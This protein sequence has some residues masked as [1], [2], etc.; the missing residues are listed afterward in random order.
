LG[1]YAVGSV[2][3]SGRL[4]VRTFD[5]PLMAINYARLAQV[6]FNAMRLLQLRRSDPEADPAQLQE[7][8]ARLQELS[9]SVAEDLDVAEE[10][11]ISKE[12]VAAT[13]AARERFIGWNR[14][15]RQAIAEGRS[16]SLHASLTDHVEAVL[17]AFDTLGEVMADDGF[18]D[19]E[20]SLASVNHY[21]MISIGATLGALALGL[22]IAVVLARQMVDPIAA[23]SRAAS[24]IAAGDLDA[25]ILPAGRDELG[26]LLASMAVMRENIR[27]MMEKEIAARR[28]AQTQL[29]T[30]IESSHEG[31]ALID[32][33]SRI[34]IANSPI[35][36]F[37]AQRGA[38]FVAGQRLPNEVAHALAERTSEMQL[39]DGQWLRLS[40][41][42]TPE[43]GFVLIA[44]DI[45]LLKAREDAL[46]SA[47]DDAEAANRAK[48][49]FLATMSH[50]L[51]TPLSAVIGFSELIVNETLGP[52]G[53]PQYREFAADILHAGKHLLDVITDI[54]DVAKAQSGTTVLRLNPLR[55][56]GVVQDAVRIV[57]NK[58]QSAGLT[59]TVDIE[60]PLPPLRADPV[61]LRQILL[62]LLSNAIK[63]TPRGG[64]V[65]VRVAAFQEGLAIEVADT[66]IGMAKDDIPRAMEP[67]VQVD[68]S[69]NR[70]HGGTG[71]GLPLTKLFTE[72]HGGRLEIDSQP[73]VGTTVTVILPASIEP[74]IP[75]PFVPAARTPLQ[76]AV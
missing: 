9:Q 65:S 24:R 56:R 4:V 20:R 58:A 31:V 45:T 43:G 23:A 36:A 12:A 54:L 69:L 35:M 63:F 52:I 3:G 42:D 13:R 22:L 33:D 39:A 70:R 49:D 2:V 57:R 76:I 19:R 5:K 40:R 11:S 74:V 27:A 16:T 10:R 53:R 51:R 46:R 14:A 37:F 29:V 38:T 55:P 60:E 8:D 59:L 61:R 47:R 44:S 50:E 34:L 15:R 62:N 68:A 21:K 66:G 48:T 71:L 25:E 67:F 41:S 6:E 7:L 28:S 72:L 26:H 32:R 73:G 1:L 75:A 17:D 30:A 64:S 18:R